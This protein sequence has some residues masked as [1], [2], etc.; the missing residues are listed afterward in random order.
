MLT[1]SIGGPS[2]GSSGEHYPHTIAVGLE[3]ISDIPANNVR[4]EYTPLL[5][6]Q[7]VGFT[8]VV[9]GALAKDNP[10]SGSMLVE[11][12]LFQAI[13]NSSNMFIIDALVT[14]SGMLGGTQNVY[15]TSA[16]IVYN[17]SDN[18]FS[19]MSLKYE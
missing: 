13:T 17:R 3:N 15:S 2:T 1:A 9:A 4:A 10:L 12:S 6:G 16:K 19:F 14:Y 7:K 18:K 11:D 8:A 5:N